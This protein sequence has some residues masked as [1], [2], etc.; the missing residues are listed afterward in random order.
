MKTI[1]L[2]FIYIVKIA[3]KI[4]TIIGTNKESKNLDAVRKACQVVG[5]NKFLNDV[6]SYI[7]SSG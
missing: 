1:S 7:V 6:N 2:F 5:L 3:D 4:P